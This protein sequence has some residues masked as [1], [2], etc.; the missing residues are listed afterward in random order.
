MESPEISGTSTRR[1]RQARSQRTRARLLEATIEALIELGYAGAKTTE[2]ADRA[3]VS[4]GALY[5]HFPTKIEILGDALAD[6]LARMRARFDDRWS[7]D[8]ERETDP[9]GTV[10]RHMW[11]IFTSPELQAA[12]ELYV[13]ARTD[14]ELAARVVPAIEHHRSRLA[15]RSHELFPVDEHDEESGEAIQALVSTLQGAGM[16]GAL[17][18]RTHAL[19]TTQRRSIERMFRAEF[20][21]MAERRRQP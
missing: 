4:Q 1:P 17:L 6:L 21:R 18:S 13:A 11:D 19:A 5:K 3:G 12:F 7:T 10:F 2:I 9:A 8:P 16:V 15:A 20:A 14:D